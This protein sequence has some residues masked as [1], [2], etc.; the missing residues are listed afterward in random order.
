MIFAGDIALPFKC[1]KIDIPESLCK[2][3]WLVNLEGS[4]VD[5]EAAKLLVSKKR[6]FN[7]IS[8]LKELKDQLNIKVCSLANNHIEDCTSVNHTIEKLSKINLPSV[9]A[10]NCLGDAARVLNLQ[11]GGRSI[12]I[13]SF[14]WDVIK[15]P[16]A[17]SNKSGVN[18]YRKEYVIKTVKKVLASSENL[19]CFFHWGYEL[20]A[21]PLPYDRE[22]AHILIEL[23]VNAVIGCHAHRVQQIE[24]FK[25]KPIVYGLGNFLF[26][27]RVFW[28]GR[29]KFPE[30]TRKELAFEITEEGEFITHWFDYDID[31]NRLKFLYSER[32]EPDMDGFE[33]K[34][35]Y[36]MLS[37]KEY[38][39]YFSNNRFHKKLLPVFKSNESSFSYSAKRSF[40]IMRRILIDLLVKLNVKAKK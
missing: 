20:E 9:G 3:G 1:T 33:G 27:H 16:V 8:A 2:K 25:G 28:D 23:G 6:V 35:G 10:G 34:A 24:F 31:Q 12:S 30:F 29:L 13:L 5:E 7:N 26:P 14:G 21:L 22:L 40:V 18:P 38:D 17:T 36:S 4:I 15:C 32:I 37:S 19:I 39:T 11:E